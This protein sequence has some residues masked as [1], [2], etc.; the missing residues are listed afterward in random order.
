MLATECLMAAVLLTSPADVPLPAEV[1]TWAQVCWTPLLALA[2]DAQLFDA[3]ENLDYLRTTQD[4]VAD[5]RALQVRFR[6]FAFAPLV[7]ECERFPNR[8]AVQE[9]LAYNRWYRQDTRARLELDANQAVHLSAALAEADQ[10]YDLWC[11][12]ADT[13]WSALYV[14]ARRQ[15]LQ[16]LLDRV[17]PEAFYSGQLPPYVPVWRIPIAR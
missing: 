7:Q 10:L 9:F 14:T 11:V 3:R 5:L 17:G 2:L 1:A 12:V 13:S 4:A 16:K 15:A 8:K 6:D